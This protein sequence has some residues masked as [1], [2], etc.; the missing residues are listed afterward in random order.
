MKPLLPKPNLHNLIYLAKP[1]KI[2]TSTNIISKLMDSCKV[3]K[4]KI[5]A[6]QVKACPALVRAQPQLVQVNSFVKLQSKS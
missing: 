4:D 2:K 3:N 5:T 1:S 6:R